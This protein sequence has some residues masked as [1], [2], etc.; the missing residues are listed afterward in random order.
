MKADDPERISDDKQF[1]VGAFIFQPLQ[2]CNELVGVIAMLQ[3]AVA[4]QMQV[5]NQIV[6][7]ELRSI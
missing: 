7:A 4:T 3:G 2:K 1:G 6:C 5:T